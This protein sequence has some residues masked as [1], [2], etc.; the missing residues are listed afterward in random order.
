MIIGQFDWK[1]GSL[2]SL[3]RENH[4]ASRSGC[5]PRSISDF[6]FWI[7]KKK[8]NSNLKFQN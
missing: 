4:P 6:G 2:G 5:H 8:N 3:G 7:G 1:S